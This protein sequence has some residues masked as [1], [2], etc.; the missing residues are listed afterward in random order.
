MAQWVKESGVVAAAVQITALAQIQSLV[1]ELPYATGAA[2]NIY[3]HTHTYIYTYNFYIFINIFYSE[4]HFFNTVIFF[5][6][7]WPHL[8][9]M[10]IPGIGVKQEL[11]LQSYTTTTAKLDPSYIYDLYHSLQQCQILKP[12]SEGRD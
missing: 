11:Q 7:L 3:I 10:E 12:P 4:S 6:F 2:T 5:S 8:Q 1:Q 9:H